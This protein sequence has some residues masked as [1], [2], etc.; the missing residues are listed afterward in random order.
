M[1]SS[2]DCVLFVFGWTSIQEI[3]EHAVVS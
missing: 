2:H 1:V 3:N